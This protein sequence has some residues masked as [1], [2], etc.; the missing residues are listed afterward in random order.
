MGIFSV[1]DVELCGVL[2]G[3]E[4]AWQLDLRRVIIETDSSEVW[5]L[6]LC[7]INMDRVS[8]VVPY[9]I[10]IIRKEWELQFVHVLREGN[11]VA[12]AMAWL[13][14]SL[15]FRLHTFRNPPTEVLLKYHAEVGAA[16]T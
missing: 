7:R 9:L 15:S 10:E 16:R 2:E 1:L 4:L 11:L 3:L 6:L 12:D 14:W 13:A 8:S 5:K